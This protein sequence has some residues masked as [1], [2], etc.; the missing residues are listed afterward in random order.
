MGTGVVIIPVYYKHFGLVYGTILLIVLALLSIYSVHYL[1][2]IYNISNRSGF[3]T[4]ARLSFGNK[5]FIIVKIVLIIHSFGLA[6][7]NF[8]ILGNVL[9]YLI[10]VIFK[11]YIKDTFFDDPWHNWFYILICAFFLIFTL[12]F[13]KLISLKVRL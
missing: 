12:F 11:A 9:K 13:D 2:I 8:R 10:N 4:L 1:L 3:S 6:C 5:G 7:A